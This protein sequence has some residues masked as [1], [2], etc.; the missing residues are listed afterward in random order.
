MEA[1]KGVGASKGIAI[2]TAELLKK[3]EIAVE[4]KTVRDGKA[5]KALFHQARKK[6]IARLQE[7][8]N[9][10]VSRVGEA[11][12]EIFQ[13]HALMLED[14]D[15]V[16]A[17]EEMITQEMVWASW[18]VQQV[19]ERFTQF[20]SSMDDSYMKERAADVE[21]IGRLLIR[22]LLGREEQELS[23]G[24]GQ[25]ILCAEDLM[26]SE[27][28]RLDRSR[29]LAFVTR[30]GSVLS[31]SAILARA[32]GI[33]SVVALGDGFD[34]ILPGDTLIVDGTSGEVYRNPDEDTLARCR[35]RAG[36]G[37]GP[38]GENGRL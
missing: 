38:A 7:L 28:V 25:V 19:S 12:A 21:D 4:R 13:I 29:I 30:S 37:I 20:F 15:Y 2:G 32:M 33:P 24:T 10:I 11:E 8:Y 14:L 26:P 23:T 3:T 9:D 22:S 31:H 5:E 18:A 35:R 1:I 27:T 16:K 6:S 34:R 17:V 36:R